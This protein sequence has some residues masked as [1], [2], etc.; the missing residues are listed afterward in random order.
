MGLGKTLQAIAAARL[1]HNL[2]GMNSCLVVCPKSVLDHWS[3]ELQKFAG[4]TCTVVKGDANRRRRLYE[5]PTLFKTVT[6]ES[7]REDFPAIGTPDLIIFDE[8]Q[9]LANVATL[10]NRVIQ[11]AN[12][13]F[14]FGLSGTAVATGLPD[15]YGVLKAMRAP[16]LGRS[17]DFYASHVISDRFGKPCFTMNAGAFYVRHA[18]CILRRLKTEVEPNLPEIKIT[19][20]DLELSALQ[21]EMARPLLVELEMVKERLELRYDTDDFNR[22]RWLINRIAELSDST[23]LL[24]PTTNDSS[25]LTWLKEYLLSECFTDADKVVIFTRWTRSQDLICKVCD[26]IGIGFETLRGESTLSERK[27]A[28]DRFKKDQKVRAFVSTDAGG[29]GINLQFARKV[30][31]FEPS[32]SPSTDA[33]RIQRVHRIGQKR[34]VEAVY[35]LTF[36]DSKFVLAT[37]RKKLFS[38]NA[39]DALRSPNRNSGLPTWPELCAVIRYYQECAKQPDISPNFR[40][41]KH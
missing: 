36:L 7:L 3:H 5:A 16:D 19:E 27:N 24:D 22:S 14:F 20:V 15:L 1:L 37:H 21:L 8:V 30:V 10:S 40:S 4:E 26:E 33:Q 41:K 18:D 29:V 39:I 25:K 28:I 34:A 9:K 13:R 23:A 12:S 6:I 38:A 11:S 32:W 31:I 17:L 35:L 2:A